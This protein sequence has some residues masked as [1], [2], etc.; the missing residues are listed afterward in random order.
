[1][2][3]TLMQAPDQPA[4]EII[5]EFLSDDGELSRCLSGFSPRAQQI[6]MAQAIARV[7]QNRSQLISEAGTGTGKT[8][9]YLV[10]ALL[11]GK[12]VI[13]ST[14]TKNLQDQLFFKDLPVVRQ[15]LGVARK[16]ALLKGRANYLCQYRMKQAEDD[17]GIFTAK[18]QVHHFQS[19]LSW[20]EQT[21]RGDIAELSDVPEDSMVWQWVTST[22]DNCLGQDCDYYDDCFVL[23]ARKKAQAADIVVINHHLF[24]ADLSL[25]EE[26][27]GDLLPLADC[28]MLDEAHQLP[29]VAANFFGSSISARQLNELANDSITEFHKE[30]GD[31]SGIKEYADKLEKSVKDFRLALGESVRRAAWHEVENNEEVIEAMSQLRAALIEMSGV[32]KEAAVR[33]KELEACWERSRLMLA[34]FAQVNDAS[35]DD[36]VRWFETY[37]TSFRINMTPLDIS[38]MFQSQMEKM[39]AAWVFTS[40]TLAVDDDFSH[41]AQAMGIEDAEFVCWDSPFNYSRQALLYSPEGMPDP[42]QQDYTLSLLEKALPVLEASQGRAFMLFTSYRAMNEAAL[43]LQDNISFSLLVQGQAPK[44]ELINQFKRDGHSVLL[45]T[46]SFWEGVDVRGEALSC[47][48]I[49]KLPFG[50]PGDP[51]NQARIESMKKKGG[52]PFFDFQLPNAVISLKQGV[53]RLIR[54]MSDRGVLMLCDPRLHSKSYGKTFLKSLPQMRRTRR[55]VDVEQFFD[56]SQP[57]EIA[58]P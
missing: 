34:K 19:V 42:N 2:S 47:V 37:K 5:Q 50:S 28:L 36:V 58:L 24:C 4:A 44:V 21:T 29:E 18:E 55:I 3:A 17:P 40:A 30:A 52:N 49:D 46:S 32:L 25:K 12:R 45:G 57:D 51:V 9:A 10:P 22:N 11:S 26:G 35:I 53:G 8:F 7:I 14:G 39:Q 33:S 15:A 27:F 13:I 1:M 41:Y 48:I 43:W 20:A 56:D 23:Q 38:A 6:E 31:M 54:D 16:V